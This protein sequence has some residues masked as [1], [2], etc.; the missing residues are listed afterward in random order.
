M[1]MINL[2]IVLILAFLLL[3]LMG[4]RVYIALGL[5]ATLYFLMQGNVFVAAQRMARTIDTFTLVAV[6][7]FIFVGS[8]INHGDIADKLFKF[9]SNLLGPTKG[10]LAYVNI[11]AS[12]IFSGMSGSALADIGGIGKVIMTEMEK[13]GYPNPY[14]AALTSSAAT[15]G[16]L[17]PP[18]IPLIIFG[19]LAGVS[20]L[21]LLLAGVVP[22]LILFVGLGVVTMGL[23]VRR[24]F[25][26][27][28]DDF[29]FKAMGRS[30]VKSIPALGAPVVLIGG[31]LTGTFGVTE[32]A[33]VTVFYILFINLVFYQK[34]EAS[35]I[36]TAAKEAV[37]T[38]AVILVL[39][40][41]AGIFAKVITLERTHLLLAD[42]LFAVSTDPIALLI[43][44]NLLLLIMGLFMEPLSAMLISIPIVVPTLTEVGVDPVH[45]GVIMVFN[46]MIG[47]ITPPLG[48]SLF[49]ASDI[50]GAEY[51]DTMRELAPYYVV[52]LVTLALLTFVPAFSLWVPNLL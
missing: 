33:A 19:V 8:L 4:F 22:A 51:E 27:P 28:K 2:G 41:T 52:L 17:F 47:L 18:S 23:S 45:I 24:D 15:I 50:A 26:R 5:P 13:D 7:L 9:A 10:G 30:F 43:M 49:L 36:W 40:A 38:T 11:L 21:Q 34:V 6:P 48:L 39:L 32:V 25:P 12:L 1:A 14:S 37:Q 16:P 29:D 3:T 44:V 42:V 31:M 35:Y 20:V 46:L